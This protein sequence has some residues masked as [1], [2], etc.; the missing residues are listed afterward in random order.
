MLS[1]LSSTTLNNLSR[2]DVDHSGLGPPVP[3]SDQDQLPQY[4]QSYLHHPKIQTFLLDEARLCQCDI[5]QEQ[6][7]LY[8]LKQSVKLFALHLY[9]IKYMVDF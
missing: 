4:C 8:L 1:Y 5:L 6:K 3:I 2:G 9:S 7:L